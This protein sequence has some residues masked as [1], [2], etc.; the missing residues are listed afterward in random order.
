MLP[1]NWYDE[2]VALAMKWMCKNFQAVFVLF[3]MYAF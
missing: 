1:I 2:M 3:S